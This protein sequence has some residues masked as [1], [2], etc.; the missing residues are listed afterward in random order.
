MARARYN[1]AQLTIE[2]FDDTPE[3]TDRLFFAL[4]P[5]DAA[6]ERIGGLVRELQQRHKLTA[7]PVPPERLHL[8][9]FHVGDFLGLPQGVV[10]EACTVAE[11]IRMASFSIALERV[12][13]FTG[14]PGNLPLVLCGAESEEGDGASGIVVAKAFQHLLADT[15][16]RAGVNK[17]AKGEFTP[18]VTLMYDGHRVAPE[19]VE[20]V[21]WSV[22]EFVLVHSM[23]G[24]SRYEILGR[25]PLTA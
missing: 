9:L 8:S 17:G 5:D 14:R 1:P 16:L 11:S 22:R 19:V 7:K 23:V 15:M 4:M 21:D 2:G 6:R 24:R 13:S 3:P 25:W 18:H 10:R 12:M 20:R